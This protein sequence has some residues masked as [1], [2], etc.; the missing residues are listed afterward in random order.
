M[1]TPDC[2]LGSGGFGTDF[3]R[4]WNVSGPRARKSRSEA[5]QHGRTACGCCRVQ[6]SV[7]DEV[8]SRVEQ[9]QIVG[10]V[11]GMVWAVVR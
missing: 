4:S 8:R 1:V 7:S 10:R 2:G 11:V 6:L 5:V 9:V 3:A